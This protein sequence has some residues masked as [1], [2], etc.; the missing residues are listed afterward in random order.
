MISDLIHEETRL[1]L[2][3]D[4]FELHV[5]NRSTTYAKLEEL[6]GLDRK[7]N[8]YKE[9]DKKKEKGNTIDMMNSET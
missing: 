2:C 8:P 1:T 3:L 5:Y 4:T 9:K 6:F 7:I